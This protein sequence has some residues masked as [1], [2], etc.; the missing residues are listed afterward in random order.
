[1]TE[2]ARALTPL[3]AA[4]YNAI[5]QAVMETA[6]GRWFLREYAA[7]N[8]QADTNILLDAIGR[9]ERAVSGERAMQQV[10]R[11]RFDL[12]EMAKSIS[13]L[14]LELDASQPD[15]EERSQFDAA[16]SA[17]DAIVKTTE[18]ATSSIL[19]ATET[20]QEVAWG[21]REKAVDEEACD[22]IDKLAADIYTACAFQDLTAQQ[23]T[24]VVRTL[25]FLEGRIN[26]LVDA[27]SARDGLAAPV[28]DAGPSDVRDHFKPDLSQ[29]DI[30]IVIVS[31]DVVELAPAEEPESHIPPNVAA[32]MARA[33]AL[34]PSGDDDG[35]III[36]DSE[37][38]D[39]DFAGPDNAPEHEAIALAPVAHA[40]GE[41]IVVDDVA[42]EG[43]RAP[44]VRKQA[45]GAASPSLAEI[46]AMPTTG[47]VLIFG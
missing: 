35:P 1:M 43:A 33:A 30:D 15:G 42:V 16:A 7:R 38:I 24:K 19:E 32:A 45:Q 9:L 22:R 40:P 3:T 37:M 4:D 34:S 21:L 36:D 18:R 2:D 12:L 39:V 26:A 8:R 47:K 20:V 29:S 23:T 11:I 41:P 27:W 13:R 5:E 46:D 25:R 14:K 28:E 10:E 6:R 31:E 44:V 17:L